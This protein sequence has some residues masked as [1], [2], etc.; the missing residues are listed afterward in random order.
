MCSPVTE[1]ML[2]FLLTVIENVT[3]KLNLKAEMVMPEG[4]HY[5]MYFKMLTVPL[6][7]KVS[8]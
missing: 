6:K 3:V 7:S 8:Y 4:V 1:E 5:S 2:N